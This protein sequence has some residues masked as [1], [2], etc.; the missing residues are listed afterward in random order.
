MALSER[1]VARAVANWETVE[2]HFRV[3]VD[4]ARQVDGPDSEAVRQ[5]EWWIS[6]A[7]AALAVL[8]G[9]QPNASDLGRG[10]GS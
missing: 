6:E 5:Y 4:L 8:R 9:D 10:V 1:A 7:L 2:A 3:A